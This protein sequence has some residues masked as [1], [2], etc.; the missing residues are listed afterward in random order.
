M[1]AQKRSLLA[2]PASR[3]RTAAT[4][5]PFPLPRQG[6]VKPTHRQMSTTYLAVRYAIGGQMMCDSMWSRRG[7]GERER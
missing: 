7:V 4:L 1:K 2:W 6:R 3:L 5:A